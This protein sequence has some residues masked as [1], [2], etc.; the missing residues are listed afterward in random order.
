M[1]F[2]KLIDIEGISVLCY[3]FHTERF[4]LGEKQIEYTVFCIEN[5]ADYFDK[6]G[7]EIYNLLKK[8]GLLTSYVIPSY[9]AL[10]TQSK[11]YIVQDI[12]AAMKGKGLVA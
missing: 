1:V 5:V 7:V 6:T 8:S 9:D 12:V 10:H 3:T 2:Q 11:Q 4:A